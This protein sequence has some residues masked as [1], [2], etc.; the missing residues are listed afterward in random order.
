MIKRLPLI[1]LALL[2]QN[3]EAKTFAESCPDIQTC[4]NAVASILGQKYIFDS[5]V[6]GK[7]ISTSNFELTKENAELLFTKALDMNRY[8]RVPLSQPGMFQIMSQREARDSALPL[9]K[10]DQNTAPALPENWDLVTMQYQA[11]HKEPGVVDNI[12]RSVRSFMP[13]NSRIIPV[14]MN[15]Q[16]LITDS[17]P[18]LKKIYEIIKQMDVKPNPEVSLKKNKEEMKR[19]IQP[20]PESKANE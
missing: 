8:A 15:G 6:K 3:G 19:T 16:L 4:A 1:L 17:A 11:T 14:A 13:A 7:I 20:V 9:I 10:S 5:E 2:I 12:A 18:N